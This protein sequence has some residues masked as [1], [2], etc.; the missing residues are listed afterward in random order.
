MRILVVEDSSR[1]AAVLKKGL[2]EECYAVDVAADGVT[3]LH[4]AEGGEYDLVLLD[5]NLPGMDGFALI[6]TLREKRSDVP[7]I[8]VT[9]R[10]SVSDRIAGLDCGADDYLVKPFAFEELLARIRATMRRAGAR[11]EPVLRFEDIVLDPAKGHAQRD[12]QVINLSARE[13]ALLRVFLANADRVMTRSR[14]YESVWNAEYDGLSNV[15]DVYVNYL[16]NKLEKG[17]RPRVIHTVRGR[18]YLFGRPPGGQ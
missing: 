18:G 12:G 17:G 10:D 11:E 7:V 15:L 9:A 14:L 8:M 16:R 13:F 4:L 5:V 6:R 3:G 2:T 1:M